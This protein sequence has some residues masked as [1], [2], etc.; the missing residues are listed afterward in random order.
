MKRSRVEKVWV[1]LVRLQS[2][3]SA[4]YEVS[5]TPSGQPESYYNN[6]VEQGA[7]RRA[8]LDLTRALANMRKSPYD[9]LP[10]EKKK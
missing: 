7:V 8:S 4:L 3:I 10:G 1:E 5:L 6:P 9:V 2:A